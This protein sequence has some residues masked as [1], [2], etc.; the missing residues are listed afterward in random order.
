[1]KN[2]IHEFNYKLLSSENKTFFRNQQATFIM[3]PRS[4]S[5]DRLAQ[6]IKKALAESAVVLGVSK[7]PFVVGLENQPQ[8]TMAPLRAAESVAKRAL[9]MKSDN[10]LSIIVYRQTEVDEVIR[11][12]RPN[13]V[14][15]VRGSYYHAFHLRSTYEFLSKKQIPYE[16][17]SPFM[18]ERQAIHYLD[19]MIPELPVIEVTKGDER[20]MLKACEEV[21]KRSFDYSF[22]TGAVLAE[23][24]EDNDYVI[25]DCASNDV[26]PYQ[27]H[28]MHFGNAREEN[29]SEYNSNAHYDT[30]HAEMNIL[31]R[32]LHSGQ[33]LKDKTLFVGLMPCPNCSRVLSQTDL[34]EIVYTGKHSGDYAKQL[35][36]KTSIMARRVDK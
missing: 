1:M 12:L 31:V 13:K 24:T 27:T 17:V 32:A 36:K 6:I 34:K 20:A 30:I 29:V 15:A 23:Q 33:S 26:V 8:F 22:Q 4:V 2:M 3:A 28:A 25:I 10:K 11:F 16:L 7:E 21:A 18:D 35:F 5:P 14:I 9:R 19:L